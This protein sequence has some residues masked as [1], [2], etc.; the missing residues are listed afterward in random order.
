[1]YCKHVGGQ[2]DVAQGRV[3]WIFS[4]VWVFDLVISLM[5]FYCIAVRLCACACILLR[6]CQHPNWHLLFLQWETRHFL[7][8]IKCKSTWECNVSSEFHRKVSSA[9]SSFSISTI[10][11]SL[12][13]SPIYHFLFPS[14]SS[15]YFNVFLILCIRTICMTTY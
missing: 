2:A 10:Q 1:M 11:V 9:V 3:M 5:F 15:I 12:W 8:Q 6:L 4:S 7:K 13:S 14:G